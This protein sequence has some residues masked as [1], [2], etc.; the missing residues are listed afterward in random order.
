MLEINQK[1]RK[2]ETEWKSCFQRL[3]LGTKNFKS[4]KTFEREKKQNFVLGPSKA[5]SPKTLISCTF[6]YGLKCV[7]DQRTLTS[8]LRGRITVRLASCL[9]GFDSTKKVNL[10]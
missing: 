4:F 5:P 9:T 3:L 10:F 8:F 6:L 1:E 2:R 7:L